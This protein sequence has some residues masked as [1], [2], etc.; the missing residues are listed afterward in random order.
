MSAHQPINLPPSPQNPGGPRHPDPADLALY[1]MQL[2]S[3]DEAATIAHHVETCAPCREELG[4]I[5]SDLA[6]CALTVDLESPSADS[7]DRLL[8]QVAREKKFVPIAEAPVSVPVPVPVKP[9][10]APFGRSGSV[11]SM[12]DRQPKPTVIR[13]TFAWAGWGVAAALAVAVSFL[14]G[15]RRALKENLA[16][17]NGQIQRLNASAASSHQLMDAL[18]DPRAVRVSL[19]AK[20]QPKSGPRGGVTYNPE[21]GTLVFLASDM[22]PLQTYKTYEL[23]VI[24]QD[25]S[26]P[27]PAGTFHPDEQGNASVIMPDLPKGVAAK[28]FGVTI[29]DN[30]GSQKPTL[31]IIM[32]G[33]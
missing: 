33:S 13:S 12:E 1:A 25:G 11:L 17:E 10:I 9:T 20:P 29:E 32:A 24:P 26:P 3:G 5:L 27:L 21:K 6:A 28:A 30:G 23:W 15:D 14:Y 8:K 18:T 19:T 22:D 7:R 2:L 31:P 16:A 4:R